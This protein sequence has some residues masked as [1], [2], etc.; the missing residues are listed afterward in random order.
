VLPVTVQLPTAF[1]QV[2][3][4]LSALRELSVHACL[5]VTSPGGSHHSVLAAV[6]LQ[7]APTAKGPWRKLRSIPAAK[8]SSYCRSGTSAW[9][10]TVLAPAANGYYRLRF[11]GNSG[12]QP[13]VSR[14]VHRWRYPTRITSFTVTPRRVTVKGAITISGRRWRHTTSWRP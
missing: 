6:T 2:T 13:S 1:R 3:V 7:H 12:L 4:S 9:H 14:V 8:G 11:A 10:A 5:N